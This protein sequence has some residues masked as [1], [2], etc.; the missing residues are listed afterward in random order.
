VICIG[1]LNPTA[2]IPVYTCVLQSCLEFVGL[3]TTG[4]L[5]AN[6]IVFRFMAC[7]FDRLDP[8]FMCTKEIRQCQ[9]DGLM[10]T[11]QPLVMSDY[12]SKICHSL[13]GARGSVVV[14]ALCYK[15]EG[16]GFDF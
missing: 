12:C 7:T 9:I 3:L 1:R 16:R 11:Q 6:I 10:G 15:S 5:L 14:K 13:V 8:L 4:Y 2:D